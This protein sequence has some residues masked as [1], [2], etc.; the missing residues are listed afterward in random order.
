MNVGG[1][2]DEARQDLARI[3]TARGSTRSSRV[4]P[5]LGIGWLCTWDIKPKGFVP[6]IER[7]AIAT[8]GREMM[9]PT[10]W[11]AHLDFTK[12]SLSS[13]TK[14]S[15]RRHMRVG[16]AEALAHVG[17]RHV[18]RQ[19]VRA[20]RVPQRVKAGSRSF[21]RA[22][23]FFFIARFSSNLMLRPRRHRP[24][25]SHPRSGHRGTNR[26]RWAKPVCRL[27]PATP[28]P[29]AQCPEAASATSEALS[30]GF[31]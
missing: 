29:Q 30:L 10:S 20:V 26:R 4:M 14:R 24:A 13:G 3:A 22:A 23:A 16:V 12:S 15:Q 19:Q 17:Q 31:E 28:A 5:S 7:G 1:D 18:R 8:S 25:V 6:S 27:P 2:L 21:L 11:G 9:N